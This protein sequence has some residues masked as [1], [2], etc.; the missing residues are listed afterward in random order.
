MKLFG[1]SQRVVKADPVMQSLQETALA[2]HVFNEK[3][4]EGN[5]IKIWVYASSR[6]EPISIAKKMLKSVT[7]VNYDVDTLDE[8]HKRLKEKLMGVTDPDEH[9]RLLSI[10]MKI[11]EKLMEYRLQRR[12]LNRD[13]EQSREKLPEQWLGQSRLLVQ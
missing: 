12:Q 8:A 5:F 11:S 4:L 3:A 13:F 6:F 1:F 9:G 10:G 7:D 2:Q